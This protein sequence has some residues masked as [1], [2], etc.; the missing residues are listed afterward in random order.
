MNETARVFRNK[1][2]PSM[3]IFEKIKREMEF[4]VTVGA[5]NWSDL[6]LGD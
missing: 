5:R 2:A 6:M 1:Q 4:W 3:V